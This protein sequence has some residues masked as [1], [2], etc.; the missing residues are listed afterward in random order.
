[1]LLANAQPLR[2]LDAVHSANWQAGFIQV[3]MNLPSDVDAAQAA[4]KHPAPVQPEQP[5]QLG[6]LVLVQ[7]A[8]LL[9][10]FTCLRIIPTEL[11]S[12]SCK[13]LVVQQMGTHN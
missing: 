7:M 10:I 12:G 6:Q 1:M 4:K 5:G 13:C 9:R 3:A 11:A 8:S 2:A